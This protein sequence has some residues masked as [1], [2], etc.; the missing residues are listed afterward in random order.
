ML[1]E[2]ELFCNFFTN[3]LEI[4]PGFT[5]LIHNMEQIGKAFFDA[6][7]SFIRQNLHLLLVNFFQK[8][9]RNLCRPSLF[10]CYLP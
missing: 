5:L 9:L 2:F 3:I 8:I 6:L 1:L 10:F 7:I 4:C